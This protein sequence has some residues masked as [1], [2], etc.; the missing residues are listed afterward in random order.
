M[1]PCRHTGSLRGV[2][3]TLLPSFSILPRVAPGLG[4]PHM[5]APHFLPGRALRSEHPVHWPGALTWVSAALWP[6]RNFS[7]AFQLFIQS[8]FSTE[9]WGC[10][11]R[12]C[13]GKESTCQ[14]RR[15]GLHP[16]VG[17]I[18]WKRKWQLTPACLPGESHGQRSPWGHN[19]AGMTE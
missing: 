5:S 18:P 4:A 10:F 11:P 14:C 8:Y 2:H 1:A 19:E 7:R 13:S 15:P 9:F 17:K 3:R 6:C 12:W 16:W